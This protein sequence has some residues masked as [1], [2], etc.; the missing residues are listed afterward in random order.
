MAIVTETLAMHKPVLVHYARLYGALEG[1]PS[2]VLMF[3]SNF[4][5]P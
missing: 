4:A 1:S 5:P 3:C 2:K